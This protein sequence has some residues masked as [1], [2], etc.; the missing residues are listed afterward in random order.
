MAA[1]SHN[2]M[3][4]AELTLTLSFCYLYMTK[5]MS[6]LP[7]NTQK[8]S[9]LSF[10]KQRVLNMVNNNSLDRKCRKH[11]LQIELIIFSASNGSPK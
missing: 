10:K 1:V 6:D 11:Q 4:S 9:P 8:H 3:H 7:L 5:K 2:N